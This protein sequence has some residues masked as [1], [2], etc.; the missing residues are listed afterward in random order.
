MV[1]IKPQPIHRLVKRLPYAPTSTYNAIE[2]LIRDGKLIKIKTNKETYVDIPKEYQYQKQKEFF[3]KA[4]SY[5]I[6]PEIV[7]RKQTL[8]IWKTLDT[9]R[10]V[11]DLVQTTKLSEK[12]IRKMLKILSD[13]GIVNFEKRKPLIAVQAKDHPLT[14]L[15]DALVK[16]PESNERM[17]TSGSTPFEEII[18]TP[19]EIEKILYDKI[20]ENLTIKR[21]SFLIKGKK[22][23]IAILE[24]VPVKQTLENMF[25]TKFLTPEGVEDQCIK[26]LAQKHLDYD[27]L[28]NQAIE[29]NL[30]NQIGCYLDIINDIKQ[31]VPEI[32]IKK[33]H[34]HISDKKPVFLKDEKKYGKSGWEKKYEQKWN[35]DLYLDIGAIQHGVRAL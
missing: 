14:M 4:L 25:L 29:K 23:K 19:Q 11:N 21:T 7:L 2:A 35:V 31:I 8:R 1:C 10:T 24:S 6:D 30:V 20:D 32:V 17:Y 26:M 16:T 22:G 3:I 33:F 34:N 9:V 5:G 13:A 28:L 27:A 18:A 12:T 15:L